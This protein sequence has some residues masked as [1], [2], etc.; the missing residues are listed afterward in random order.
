MPGVANKR[1]VRG[2]TLRFKFAIV[3]VNLS[4]SDA[5]IQI[6]K[7]NGGAI[8]MDSAAVG[9]LTKS[10]ANSE[11]TIE[12]VIPFSLTGSLIGKYEYDLETTL[13]GERTTWVQGVLEVEPDITRTA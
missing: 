8:V 11:T 10:W 13:T 4:A 6:R 9:T 7:P 2:D 3:G 5:H 12:W 1:A